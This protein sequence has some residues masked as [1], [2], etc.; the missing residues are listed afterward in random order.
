MAFQDSTRRKITNLGAVAKGTSNPLV[1]DIPKTGLLGGIY[2]NITGTAS[3]TITGPNALGF[4]SIVR[5]VKLTAN[6]GIDLIN[7]S[8]AGY[9]Y[10][11]RYYLENYIDPVPFSNAR[12]VV[13][14]A[15]FDLSM[16]LPVALNSRDPLG[17]FMLQN[18]QT[19]LQLSVEFEAD[20]TV[21]TGAT[22]AA[23]VT[24]FIEYYTV[25]A[26]KK[27][28][29]ALN[30]AHVI[31]E[32]QRVVSGA[33]DF[34]YKWPRGNTYIQMLHGLGINQA[35]ADTWSKFMVYVNQ[36]DTLWNST[37][38]EQNL[39]FG[40]SHG[41]AR[42]LG[43]IQADLIGSVG[44]GCFG[45]ARDLLDSRQVTELKSVLTATGAATLYTVRRQ[46][47]QLL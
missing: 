2:L 1:F 12:S 47:V 28:W 24:P 33:G 11:L 32:D 15:A 23:T 31:I 21:G 16:Y 14:A 38:G 37:P 45:G 3:G 10:M 29:P 39:E 6:S 44:L 43:L 46:F 17:L 42:P 8:G 4:A 18:E 7:I 9:H 19:L 30:L 40:E 34:E 35:G 5:R 27:D 20:A 13:S 22:I 41:I 36:S 25:P 26:D